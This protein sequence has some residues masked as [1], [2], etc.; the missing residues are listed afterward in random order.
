MLTYNTH[1]APLVLPEY[2]RNIQNMVDHCL[3]IP[4]R[5]ERTRC[6]HTIVRAMATLFPQAKNDDPSGRKFWDALALMSGFTLDIDWPFEPVRP[7]DIAEKPEPLPYDVSNV[8]LRQYGN[9]VERMVELA[10]QMPE[11]EERMALI[12]LVANQM[13]KNLLAINHDDDPDERIYRDLYN[14][15]QGAIQVDSES[16]PLLAFDVVAP[17]TGKKKKK[18]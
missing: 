2:G 4:D 17:P 8:G 6:A 16:L 3:M 15:S 10:A 12:T 5:E 13:K 1:L 14:M 9:N 11:G 18:K 7:E